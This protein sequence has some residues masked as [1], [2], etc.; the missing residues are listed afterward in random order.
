MG[1]VP[2]PQ[3]PAHANAWGADSG[4]A[5]AHDHAAWAA[6]VTSAANGGMPVAAP[7]AGGAQAWSPQ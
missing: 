2:I 3:P 6:A 1:P 5:A 4:Y 7:V